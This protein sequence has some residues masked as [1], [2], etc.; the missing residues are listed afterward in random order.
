MR[1]LLGISKTDHQPHG[2]P[3]ICCSIGQ[4]ASQ[5]EERVGFVNYKVTRVRCRSRG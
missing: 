5:G 3:T 4:Q 2:T 1:M